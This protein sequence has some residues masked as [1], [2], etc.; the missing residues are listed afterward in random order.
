[1]SPDS[2]GDCSNRQTAEYF[3]PICRE[4][5]N[6]PAESGFLG[7]D[8]NAQFCPYPE[9]DRVYRVSVIF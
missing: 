2:V 4:N 3:F 9:D 6:F 8:A 1:M 5:S 7:N